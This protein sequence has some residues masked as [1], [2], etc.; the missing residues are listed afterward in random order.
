MSN[1]TKNVTK[2]SDDAPTVDDFVNATKNIDFS[3]ADAVATATTKV[4]ALWQK[5]NG[6]ARGPLLNKV[7]MKL[8][9]DGLAKAI[10]LVS[11]AKDAAK[12]D[13]ATRRKVELT[14]VQKAA[15][16][17]AALSIAR[18]KVLST[19]DFLSNDDI[20]AATS[21]AE[22]IVADKVGDDIDRD[23]VMKKADKVFD[24]IAN[25]GDNKSKTDFGRLKFSDMVA[26]GTLKSGAVLTYK[27][28][29]GTVTKDGLKIGSN[30]FD[31]PS[32]A[33]CHVDN[34]KTGRNGWKCWKTKDD[35]LLK[36]IV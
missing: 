35:V 17:L 25:F 30:V 16:K 12:S 7:T 11:E 34:V 15:M 27:G 26:D 10:V 21:M 22:A 5:V 31:T 14:D 8:A 32:S 36:D 3:D 18:N 23:A 28:T 1:R 13:G 19:Y 9:Q 2:S 4:V 24:P 6:G 20:V 29:K 33:A